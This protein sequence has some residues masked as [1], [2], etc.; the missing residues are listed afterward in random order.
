MFYMVLI[1]ILVFL[2]I[3]SEVAKRASLVGALIITV[4]FILLVVF[5]LGPMLEGTWIGRTV[6]GLICA[7]YDWAVSQGYLDP[8]HVYPR[9]PYCQ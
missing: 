4:A 3:F 8:A 2:V 6:D 9:V 5:F 1:G 7:V